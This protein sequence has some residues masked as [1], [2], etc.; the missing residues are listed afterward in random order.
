[1]T[2]PGSETARL[3]AVLD[4]E[5]QLVGYHRVRA[6]RSG[7]HRHIDL[8]LLFDPEMSLRD[9]HRLAEELEDR[10]RATLPNVSIV[11]HL[12]PATEEELAVPASEPG[13]WKGHRR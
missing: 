11:S 3:R 13:I 12:E 2:L 10:I 8:H 1:V 9:A 5:P 6:R 4:A 7:A